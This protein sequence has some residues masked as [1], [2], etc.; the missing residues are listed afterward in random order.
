MILLKRSS[1]E[2]SLLLT[3]VILGG[4]ITPASA[5]VTG[6]QVQG[7][8]VAQNDRLDRDTLMRRGVTLGVGGAAATYGVGKVSGAAR[9][10]A[11]VG[12]VRSVP[13]LG[14]A[15]AS[16]PIVGKAAASGHI[17]PTTLGQVPVLGYA[18]KRVPIVGPVVAGPANPILVG[19]VAIDNYVIPKYSPCGYTKSSVIAATNDF[20]SPPKLRGYVNY[21]APLPYTH[22]PIY[23]PSTLQT[24][25]PADV[26]YIDGIAPHTIISGLT[27]PGSATP[28]L[29]EFTASDYSGAGTGGGAAADK[30]TPAEGSNELLSVSTR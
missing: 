28:D 1:S 10:V 20:N 13:H 16:L 21:L 29:T 9:G 3:V 12:K 27:L 14:S 7:A 23:S 2:I 22:P 4:V 15:T 11:N 18:V 26:A 24:D 25:L 30:P 19:A 17:V 5:Q 8:P 6:V